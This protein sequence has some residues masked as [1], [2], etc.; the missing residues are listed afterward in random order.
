MIFILGLL[1]AE[2]PAEVPIAD[3]KVI[4]YLLESDEQNEG[5]STTPSKIVPISVS[6]DDSRNLPAGL[7][8]QIEENTK[9][10]VTSVPPQ[11][12]PELGAPWW[13]GLLFGALLLGALRLFIGKQKK[14]LGSINVHSRSFF[15]HEGSIAVVEVKDAEDNPRV[16]LLGMHSKGPP[17]FLADLSAPLPFPE[18]GNPQES[19]TRKTN[20]EGF[21]A[22]EMEN[23]VVPVLDEAEDEEEKEALVEQILRMRET[24][25]HEAADRKD[26]KE[27]RD[28][29]A[30]GF[31]EVLRK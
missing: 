17:Q 22:S 12:F 23:K 4:N 11:A 19:V 26:S 25:T 20:V 29:W 27:K 8:A 5:I 15:G 28:R 14:T 3:Q 2:E 6:T 30:E 21:Q 16:F 31:H 13:W 1:W 10:E 7:Q 24:K 18:L 9:P